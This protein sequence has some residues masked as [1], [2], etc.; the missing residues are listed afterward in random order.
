MHNPSKLFICI[1]SFYL[2]DS[3]FWFSFCYFSF[4]CVVCW[5]VQRTGIIRISEIKEKQINFQFFSNSSHTQNTSIVN[6]FFC[7]IKRA[8]K[9]NWNTFWTFFRH[10]KL[11]PG[12]PI[13]KATLC[14]SKLNYV[15]RLLDEDSCAG[16]VFGINRKIFKRWRKRAVISRHE[17]S[18]QTQSKMFSCPLAMRDT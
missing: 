3:F 1:S 2:F 18:S 13:S 12:N 8:E 6:I 9:K 4:F 17:R 10:K 14:G 5:E 7:L 16:E 15:S 11:C